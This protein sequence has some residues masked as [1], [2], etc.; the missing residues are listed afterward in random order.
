MGCGAYYSPSSSVGVHWARGRLWGNQGCI[1]VRLEVGCA[2]L[3]LI[4]G[5]GMISFAA[6]DSTFWFCDAHMIFVLYLIRS[7]L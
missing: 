3:L 5:D 4:C 6:F 7:Q 1:V 2:E